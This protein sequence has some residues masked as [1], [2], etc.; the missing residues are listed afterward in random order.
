MLNKRIEEALNSQIQAEFY[1]AYLYLSIS[2]YFETLNLVG[3]A[4]WTRMQYEEEQGHALKLFDYV[5]ERG[6][7]AALLEIVQPEHKWDSPLAAFKE[8]LGHEQMITGRI[9]QLVNIAIEE[10]DHATVA[11]L[12]WFV[13]EQVEEEA[14]ADQIVQEMTLIKDSPSGLFMLNRELMQRTA[15]PSTDSNQK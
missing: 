8:I 5:H 1:S 2:A 12:Q 10:S 11:M 4:H 3:F 7:H 9:N 14:R 13:T 6:G 15:E